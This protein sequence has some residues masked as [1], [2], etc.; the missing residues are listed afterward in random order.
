M[1]IVLGQYCIQMS[2]HVTDIKMYVRSSVCVTVL[3]INVSLSVGLGTSKECPGGEVRFSYSTSIDD[4]KQAPARKNVVRGTLHYAGLWIEALGPNRCKVIYTLSSDPN[5]S[6]P[7]S[8]VNA[9]N[10]T[11]PLSIAQVGKL[12]AT[13][14]ALLAKMRANKAVEASK[15][16]AMKQAYRKKLLAASGGG[17]AVSSSISGNPFTAFVPGTA[18][19]E[20]PCGLSYDP[21]VAL[22]RA[23]GPHHGS[24]AAV[25]SMVGAP[26]SSDIPVTD[27]AH[28]VQFDRATHLTPEQSADL[29]AFENESGVSNPAPSFFSLLLSLWWQLLWSLFRTYPPARHSDDDVDVRLSDD[30][31][32]VQSVVPP[33]PTPCGWL[34]L[35]VA[36]VRQLVS[37]FQSTQLGLALRAAEVARSEGKEKPTLPSIPPQQLLLHAEL[38]GEAPGQRQGQVCRLVFDLA[39]LSFSMSPASIC[40]R[41]ST[42][43]ARVAL[44]LYARGSL[45][46]LPQPVLTAVKEVYAD[47]DVSGGSASQSGGVRGQHVSH[48]SVGGAVRNVLNPNTVAAGFDSFLHVFEQVARPNAAATATQALEQAIKAQSLDPCSSYKPL[49]LVGQVC[50]SLNHLSAPRPNADGIESEQHSRIGWVEL[51][52]VEGGLGAPALGTV[53]DLLTQFGEEIRSH[54]YSR[55][56]KSS[57]RTTNFQQHPLLHSKP[58]RTHALLLHSYYIS[59][60]AQTTRNSFD[61]LR[62]RGSAAVRSISEPSYAVL[63]LAPDSGNAAHVLRVAQ[64]HRASAMHSYELMRVQQAPPA[65]PRSHSRVGSQPTRLPNGLVLPQVCAKVMLSPSGH[66][67]QAKWQ[68]Q[69][70]KKALLRWAGGQGLLRGR[71]ELVDELISESQDAPAGGIVS[72]SSSSTSSSVT[73]LAQLDP[74]VSFSPLLLVSSW[75]SILSSLGWLLRLFGFGAHLLSWSDVYASFF[76]WCALLSCIFWPGLIAAFIPGGLLLLLIR[77]AAVQHFETQLDRQSG[78]SALQ[79]H[80]AKREANESAFGVSAQLH[81]DCMSGVS[82]NVLQLLYVLQCACCYAAGQLYPLLALLQWRD[83]IRSTEFAVLLAE[84][85][86]AG[87]ILPL[88]PL[89]L[90]LTLIIAMHRTSYFS[91]ILSTQADMVRHYNRLY[92]QRRTVIFPPSNVALT[93]MAQQQTAMHQQQ[94]QQKKA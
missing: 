58:L 18:F 7:K 43:H 40:F 44:S 45:E 35:S 90:L 83:E 66:I 94:Q 67:L 63:A 26:Q 78:N 62:P 52:D 41:V 30:G 39:G 88:R 47:P 38:E 3:V 82:S 22:V 69:A 4:L 60:V 28:F 5:G 81:L 53:A 84:I 16:E 29:D 11:Q 2:P 33:V 54:S 57:Q 76:A 34:W 92:E 70:S 1:R 17:S 79:F 89:L 9:A 20:D 24:V 46:L 37:T 86:L 51:R 56:N 87:L 48:Q 65:R 21:V 50:L 74:A 72:S 8:I 6:I 75:Q 12:I 85:S 32:V 19:P 49:L 93:M 23:A 73:L 36:D 77:Q 64:C 25:A 15:Q 10:V 42:P 59:S 14:P 91:L 61:L 71:K 68:D 31:S 27:R 80:R 55:S 13:N